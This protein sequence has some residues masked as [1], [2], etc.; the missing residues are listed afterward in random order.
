MG[1]GLSLVLIAGE[2]VY[3]FVMDIQ[4]L[5]S[6]DLAALKAVISANDL[7]P[8]DMLDEMTSTYLSG[9]TQDELW[10][11]VS[12]PT[13][14]ALAYARPEMMTEDTW[15]LLLIAV[16]PDRHSQGIGQILMAHM[17]GLIRSKQGRILIVETS[18]LPEFDRTRSFYERLGYDREACI[19]EF[20][21]PG[22]DKVVFR[23][24]L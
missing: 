19:R 13:P 12:D 4:P 2:S 9:E 22:D 8:P 20:Y 1:L 14:V 10:V 7:F 21:A 24:A 11:T 6:S 15:N 23:R 3:E 5:S 16:A 17:E 18:G